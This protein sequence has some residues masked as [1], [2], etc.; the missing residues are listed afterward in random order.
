MNNFPVLNLKY[1]R[2]RN[3]SSSNSSDD[4]AIMHKIEVERL[5][6]IERLKQQAL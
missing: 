2:P 3:R 1:L 4:S 6:E 5:A